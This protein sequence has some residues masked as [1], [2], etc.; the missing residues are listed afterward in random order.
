MGETGSRLSRGHGLPDEVSI[1]YL[2]VPESR[3][4]ARAGKSLGLSTWPRAAP[5]FRN[6]GQI[7]FCQ[8]A[9]RDL[10]RNR[11]SPQPWPANVS[12]K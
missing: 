5:A 6:A 4:D 2:K 3:P 10:Q 8:A 7:E 12:P 9:N 1:R 11:N